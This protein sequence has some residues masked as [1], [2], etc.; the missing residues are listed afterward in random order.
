MKEKLVKIENT[1][2]KLADIKSVD[3]QVNTVYKV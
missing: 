2:S 1:L 3:Q